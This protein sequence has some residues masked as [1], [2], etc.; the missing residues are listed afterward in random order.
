MSIRRLPCEGHQA[1]HRIIFPIPISDVSFGLEGRRCMR[2][3][4]LHSPWPRN[5][6]TRLAF[7]FSTHRL[8]CSNCRPSLSLF[9]LSP[10]FH[11]TGTALYSTIRP[12][13]SRNDG[14]STIK[15]CS[16]ALGSWLTNEV[17]PHRRYLASAQSNSAMQWPY[18]CASF[19]A[20]VPWP[21]FLD[22]HSKTRGTVPW[23]LC[24]RDQRSNRILSALHHNF[25]QTNLSFPARNTNMDMDHRTMH[26]HT[27]CK[28]I[29]KH[30]SSTGKLTHV[31]PN[32]FHTFK[33]CSPFPLVPSSIP[34][35]QIT[36]N[37]V[38]YT[39]TPSP[40]FPRRTCH[41]QQCKHVH[42]LC[43]PLHSLILSLNA[44]RSS[45]TLVYQTYDTP[46]MSLY[47]ISNPVFQSL[48]PPCSNYKLFA[49]LSVLFFP[50]RWGEMR[51]SFQFCTLPTT[52][53]T[54]RH[55][56]IVDPKNP[57]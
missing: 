1:V 41:P 20:L 37:T 32:F 2:V 39:A 48:C 25:S 26:T 50:C 43:L 53:S 44:Y 3:D 31:P 35:Y 28:F 40:P 19:H 22:R 24:I 7:L 34:P 12:M 42:H 55:P 6:L 33:A 4:A 45:Q 9:Y 29:D 5:S 8:R 54:D 16:C 52:F 11:S 10:V 30:I 21:H 47:T 46:R 18:F 17:H 38:T 23:H 57:K 36:N 56:S 51:W 14:Y 15:C 49:L 27:N 13:T